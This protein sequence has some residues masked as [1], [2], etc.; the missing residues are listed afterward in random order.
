MAWA[1]AAQPADEVASPLYSLRPKRTTLCIT[2]WDALFPTCL[3]TVNS[4]RLFWGPAWWWGNPTLS[5]G[6]GR[7]ETPQRLNSRATRQGLDQKSN[8]KSVEPKIDLHRGWEARQSKRRWL[9]SQRESSVHRRCRKNSFYDRSCVDRTKVTG[10]GHSSDV[11]PCLYVVNF[12]VFVATVTASNSPLIH[13]ESIVRSLWTHSSLHI[14][15]TSIWEFCL[16]AS[17]KFLVL[18]FFS[19]TS[20]PYFTVWPNC[21]VSMEFLRTSI[22]WEGSRPLS[23]QTSHMIRKRTHHCVLPG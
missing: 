15:I 14:L 17:M 8:V 13:A 21:W 11:S 12:P 10:C 22:S 9:R 20:G 16:W 4:S 5:E 6:W 3:S 7:G 19:F 2:T 1:E 23:L 18:L